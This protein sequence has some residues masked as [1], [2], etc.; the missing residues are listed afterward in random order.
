M[1]PAEMMARHY[2]LA[3]LEP[4]EAEALLAYAIRRRCKPGEILFRRGDPGDGLYGV[5]SGRVAVSIESLDGKELVI[6]SFTAGD[7]FGEIALLDGKGR[8]AT[9]IA[10][11][12]SELLFLARRSFLPFIEQRPAIAIRMIAFLCERLRRTTDLV[13]DAAFLD[14]ATRLAKQLLALADSYGQ[15]VGSAIRVK[16]AQA[17]LAQMIGAS[18]EAV[19]KQLSLWREAGYVRVARGEVVIEDPK[20]LAGIVE[21]A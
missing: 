4:A 12:P 9:A 11:E 18:R 7:F 16:I 3:A 14:L 19:T 21:A 2:L 17:E 10:R 8:T 13:E 15:R 6:N 1:T 5:L 20:A